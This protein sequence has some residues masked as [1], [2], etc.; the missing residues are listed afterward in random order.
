MEKNSKPG[1]KL[2]MSGNG[3]CNFTHEGNP[4]D[5]LTHYGDKGKSIKH[6]LYDFDYL[7]LTEFMN[8]LSISSFVR[9]DGKVFPESMKAEDIRDTFIREMEK[10]GTEIKFN[11]NLL[12]IRKEKDVFIIETSRTKYQSTHVLWCTGGKSCLLTG[13]NW[14]AFELLETLGHNIVPVKPA[15]CPPVIKN[16]HYAS[17]MGISFKD[18]TMT[19]KKADNKKKHFKGDM[20]FTHFGVSGP[21]V[22]DAS[23]YFE[24]GDKLIFNFSPF[25]TYEDFQKDFVMLIK[26]N[27]RK[28]IKNL[29][30]YYPIPAA[31]VLLIMQDLN[32]RNNA[33]IHNTPN[34]KLDKL[35]HAIYAF[36]LEIEKPGSFN[37]AMA[38]HGGVSLKEVNSKT[39]ESKLFKGLYFAGEVLDVDG[40]TGGYNIHFAFASAK[41]AI[42]HI[43]ES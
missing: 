12:S 15:L 30:A 21:L 16:F 5:F 42:D 35:L 37:I 14:N 18:I 23:R 22:L 6:V 29:L 7:K 4:D 36:E 20:L 31:L 38:T 41:M 40:D 39:M 43:F 19:L 26:R 24:G 33:D 8:Q 27:P 28:I 2:L 32:I 1:I 3:Q 25:K 9:E 13:T 17:L 34:T 11:Q 10:T